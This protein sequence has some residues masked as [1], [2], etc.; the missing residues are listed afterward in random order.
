MR[1]DEASDL[2]HECVS[3]KASKHEFISNSALSRKQK[4][5][6][7]K[8]LDNYFQVDGKSKGRAEENRSNLPKDDFREIYFEALNVVISSIRA[9]FDQ[10]SFVT[11]SP[12]LYS[13]LKGQ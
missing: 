5:L 3:V 10:L 13:Q 7:Y 6:N 11:S 8:L 2:F 1:I 9:R 4:H 12:I